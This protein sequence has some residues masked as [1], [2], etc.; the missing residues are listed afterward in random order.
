[1][2]ERC[3]GSKHSKRSLVL[4]GLLC[5]GVLVLLVVAILLSGGGQAIANT[6]G[7]QSVATGP[8]SGEQVGCAP[9]EKARRAAIE[10]DRILGLSPAL[11]SSP[12]T[13]RDTGVIE[14]E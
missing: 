6:V 9:C 12:T 7:R 11:E 2:S 8:N 5:S 1:M 14:D 10:A 13:P 3:T 4:D